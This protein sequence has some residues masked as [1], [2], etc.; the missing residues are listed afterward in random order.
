LRL[1][2]RLRPPRGRRAF[3]EEIR[4]DE[5]ELTNGTEDR[6]EREL[7]GGRHIHKGAASVSG[8]VV[9]PFTPPGADGNSS[10]CT[11][12]PTSLIDDIVA[13]PAGYYVNVHTKEHPGGAIRSQLG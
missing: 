3:I 11:Q 9:V 2:R 10:G 7:G 13:N 8:P 1:H 12:S 6:E 4:G 5:P